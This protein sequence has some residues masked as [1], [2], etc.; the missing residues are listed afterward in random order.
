VALVTGSVFDLP[1]EIAAPRQASRSYPLWLAK[2]VFPNL[3]WRTLG[4]VLARILDWVR[5][6]SFNLGWLIGPFLRWI[7]L[8]ISP[9]ASIGL[10][11]GRAH[12][13][14]ARLPRTAQ[15]GPKSSV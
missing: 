8:L 15:H 11:A 4:R 5:G 7:S 1:G 9:A 14:S 6:V 2:T 12:S 3:K 10:L 13:W